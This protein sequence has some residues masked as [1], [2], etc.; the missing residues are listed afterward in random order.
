MGIDKSLYGDYIITTSHHQETYKMQANR[1]KDL[2]RQKILNAVGRL[3]ARGGFREVGI[4]AVAKEAGVDKVLIYRYFGGLPELLKAFAEE[5]DH[6]PTVTD[7]AGDDESLLSRVDPETA[8]VVLLTGHLRELRKRPLTQEIMRWEL[9]ERNDLTDM[10]ADAREKQGEQLLQMPGFQQQARAGVDI[11]AAAALIHAGITYLVVRSKTAD[12]YNGVSLRS[13]EGWQRIE[14][15][16]ELLVS[17]VFHAKPEV[18][19]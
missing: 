5:G 18:T 10:L 8:A 17:G 1:N 12:K 6:W 9:L 14:A 3:M 13:E 16:I 2:T 15:A 19:R 7:L 11:E 4:N